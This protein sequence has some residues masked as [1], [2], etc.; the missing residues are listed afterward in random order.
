VSTQNIAA[1]QSLLIADDLLVKAERVV[2][3]WLG[4]IVPV[5]QA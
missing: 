1:A 3:T 4:R 5:V 2:G